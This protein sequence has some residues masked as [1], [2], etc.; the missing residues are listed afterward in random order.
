MWHLIWVCTFRQYPF[1]YFQYIKWVLSPGELIHSQFAD[2]I[3]TDLA[4]AFICLI[5]TVLNLQNSFQNINISDFRTG[6]LMGAQTFDQIVVA[7]SHRF[8]G[9]LMNK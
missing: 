5:L 4:I 9:I 8:D 7:G 6:F 2:V 3:K 1:R